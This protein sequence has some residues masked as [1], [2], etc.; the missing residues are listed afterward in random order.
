MIEEAIL[1]FDKALRTVFATAPT[2]RLRPGGAP[3]KLK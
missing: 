1:E 2:S 3:P